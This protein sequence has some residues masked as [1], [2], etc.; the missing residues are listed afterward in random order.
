MTKEFISFLKNYGVVGLAIAVIIGGKLNALVD[1][2]V[3]EL[4]M[5]F[6]GL[7][8]PSGD[9]RN[10]ALTVGETKFGVGP[11]LAAG[12]D[13]LIVAAVV[14]VIAKKVLREE[15]VSKK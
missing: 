12:I 2:V 8:L 6:V 5:P 4:L 15:S 1:S 14:F 13:F 7:L 10:L 3:K 11:V 9:W